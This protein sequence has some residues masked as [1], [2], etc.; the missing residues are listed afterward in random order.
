MVQK[1]AHDIKDRPTDMLTLGR[2]SMANER[3]LLSFISTAVG[4][5]ASVV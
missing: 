4:L 1:Y 3:T 5:L 2:T